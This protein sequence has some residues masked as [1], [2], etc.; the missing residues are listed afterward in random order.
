MPP[1]AHENEE[2][3]PLCALGTTSP[4]PSWN[5]RRPSEI[6]DAL[7]GYGS[8]RTPLNRHIGPL[9]WEHGAMS[10]KPFVLYERR[11]QPAATGGQEYIDAPISGT[12]LSLWSLAA[13]G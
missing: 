13:A 8:P 4:G 1:P 12:A 6:G 5:R 11:A 9:T 10:K 2:L 3:P 7:V